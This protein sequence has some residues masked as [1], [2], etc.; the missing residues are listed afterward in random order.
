ML[1][2][3]LILYLFSRII[4]WGF[5]LRPVTYLSI[6]S[7]SLNSAKY[8]FHLIEKAFDPIRKLLITSIAF[9]TI[10]PVGIYC[11]AG[12]YYN[13]QGSHLGE[14]D[15]NSSLASYKHLTAL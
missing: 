12:N 3:N 6:G 11:H 13:L 1:G 8:K 7:W 15:A 5:H 2:I 4:V 9:I 14:I 10:V